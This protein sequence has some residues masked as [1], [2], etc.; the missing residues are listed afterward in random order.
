M[1]L[2]FGAVPLV[3]PFL[4]VGAA[5]RVEYLVA[6]FEVPLYRALGQAQLPA[7]VAHQD[8]RLAFEEAVRRRQLDEA[9][10]TA[11]L[12]HVESPIVVD[13]VVSPVDAGYEVLLVVLGVDPVGARA[14][15]EGVVAG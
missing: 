13:H 5:L 15:V 6:V 9:A 11:A 3:A 10:T 14:G 2:R 12:H 8:L 4:W 7:L 1:A